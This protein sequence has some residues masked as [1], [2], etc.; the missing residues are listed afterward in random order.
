MVYL[1]VVL[2]RKQFKK[3]TQPWVATTLPARRG[4]IDCEEHFH[5][6]WFLQCVLDDIRGDRVCSSGKAVH[7]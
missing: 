1:N 3:N 6:H 2:P 7:H 4:G 5:A